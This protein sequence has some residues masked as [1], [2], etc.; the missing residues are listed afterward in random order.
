MQLSP[1]TV[2][3]PI[4]VEVAGAYRTVQILLRVDRVVHQVE[5]ASHRAVHVG[6]D[7]T[8]LAVR[9]G[10]GHHGLLLLELLLLSLRLLV[11]VVMV[12]VVVRGEVG[13][14]QVGG[15]EVW[16][17]GR[18]AVRGRGS[19]QVDPAGLGHIRGRDV[20]RVGRRGQTQRLVR[21]L[22]LLLRHLQGGGGVVGCSGRYLRGEVHVGG[23]VRGLGRKVGHGQ[24]NGPS[25]REQV[26]T[27]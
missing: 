10:L 22:L 3:S 6:V 15:L 17:R 25:P 16:G 11:V 9:V 13:R 5:D 4:Y 19:R 18:A 14:G 1:T 24:R 8:C 27:L 20:E 21:L 7:D 2:G 26:R 23:V 12:V